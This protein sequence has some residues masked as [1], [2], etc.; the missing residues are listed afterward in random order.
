MISLFSF[1]IS[2]FDVVT[3]QTEDQLTLCLGIPG[4]PSEPIIGPDFVI[5]EKA[6]T[7]ALASTNARALSSVDNSEDL[8]FPPIINQGNKGS[9]AFM[10]T[11][12]YQFTYQKNHLN[13]KNARTESGDI[14]P[15]NI[16]SPDHMYSLM[17]YGVNK[18]S[19]QS[20]IAHHLK[21]FGCVSLEDLPYNENSYTN[22]PE[23]NDL[24]EALNT[25]VSSIASYTIDTTDSLDTIHNPLSS[26]LTT[27]KTFLNNHHIVTASV[28]VE[29]DYWSVKTISSD[30]HKD[31]RILYRCGAPE[32]DTSTNHAVTIVGYDDNIWCDINGDNQPQLGEYGAL[33]VANS[34]G[35]DWENEG[36]I[37]VA[38]DALNATSSVSEWEQP[39]NY[40]RTAFGSNDSNA[41]IVME[42]NNYSPEFILDMT[43]NTTCFSR[44]LDLLRYTT[45]NSTP[46]SL[47]ANQTG[48]ECALTTYNI[49][50]D[51]GD[52]CDSANSFY[53]NYI[54][55]FYSYSAWENEI[56]EAKIIDNFGNTIQQ[57]S[58]SIEYR[59]DS[60][61][62]FRYKGTAQINLSLG[63]MDYSG[64][65][66]QS[67][68]TA[69]L[70]HLTSNTNLS[71]T[72]LILAD[73]N[74]D[75][76]IK[77]DDARALS[78]LIDETSGASLSFDQLLATASE[79]K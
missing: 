77:T 51:Y 8:Q 60:D 73:V 9:C 32:A 45:T 16:A 58:L 69:I 26:K 4:E 24:I 36:F 44:A 68:V 55:G 71:N 43:V 48:T 19:H 57:L 70:R 10:S 3:A 39:S 20:D 59:S 49:C 27:L 29:T 5:D 17:N 33:K 7:V 25:R 79:A 38:Y 54:W 30:A 75:G 66:D 41:Y 72:Q 65:L 18:G 31:E 6:T 34:W 15:E 47:A 21:M 67:D 56:T 53:S 22:L 28:Y 61:I 35:T 42:V 37:W 40:R 74:Q 12:Y 1:G 78:A 76:S 14:I 23:H 64:V 62:P 13:S 52:L 50:Y 63:D 11:A 2:D 46:Q